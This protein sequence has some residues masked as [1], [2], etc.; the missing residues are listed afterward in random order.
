M[1]WTSWGRPTGPRPSAAPETWG[2]WGRRPTKSHSGSHHRV[3]PTRHILLTVQVQ[4]TPGDRLE[5][6]PAA[7]RP[8]HGAG[9]SENGGSDGRDDPGRRPDQVVRHDPG[10]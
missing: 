10:V 6:R 9:A 4:A 8:A 3:I 5:G 1:C 7:R 2:C